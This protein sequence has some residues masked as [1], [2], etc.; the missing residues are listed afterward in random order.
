MD[1]NGDTHCLGANFYPISLS[2][3]EGT[4]ITF[5][6]EYLEQSNILIFTGI[7]TLTLYYGGGVILECVQG[8]WFGNRMETSLV[9]PN[10]CQKF[11]IQICNYSNDPHRKLVIKESKYLFIPMEMKGSTCGLITHTST[12][13]EIHEYQ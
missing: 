13:N 5:L 10:Q 3:D 7:T 8:I 11:G 6:N 2:F 12:K 4:V 1:N 9:N